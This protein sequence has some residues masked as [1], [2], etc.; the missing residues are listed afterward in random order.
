MTNEQGLVYLWSIYPRGGMTVFWCAGLVIT[1]IFICILW[2]G[3]SD[4]DLEKRKNTQFVKIG[5]YKII[6]PLFF[7]CMLFL[8]SLVPSRKDFMFVVATP[9]IIESGKSLIDSLQDP[10]SKAY[11]I[12]QLMDK[13]LDKALVELDKT[14]SDNPTGSK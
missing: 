5:N 1:A 11:K 4:C 9:Y 6:V 8:S 3:Y 14:I 13:G 12:N 2:I 10:T 7:V